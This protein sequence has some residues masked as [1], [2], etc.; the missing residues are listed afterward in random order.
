M[1]QPPRPSEQNGVITGYSVLLTAL[2]GG[3]I[4][5]YNLSRFAS[6]QQIEG[7]FQSVTKKQGCSWLP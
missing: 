3:N 2:Q 7:M 1:W 4:E 6:S 5:V